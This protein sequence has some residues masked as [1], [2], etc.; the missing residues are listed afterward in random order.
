MTWLHTMMTTMTMKMTIFRYRSCWAR[1][2]TW[3]SARS[4]CT[5]RAGNEFALV[6]A[7]PLQTNFKWM[8]LVVECRKMQKKLWTSLIYFSS[9]FWR[10]QSRSSHRIASTDAAN[11]THPLPDSSPRIQRNSSPWAC[12][13]KNQPVLWCRRCC[14]IG[15]TRSANLSV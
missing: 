6:F 11:R 2:R 5:T 8:K 15:R 1:E 9:R 10:S 14:R 7:T 3:S 4:C 13:C 12:A